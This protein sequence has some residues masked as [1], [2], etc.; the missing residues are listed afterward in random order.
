MNAINY[1]GVISIIMKNKLWLG[2][3]PRGEINFITK[4]KPSKENPVVE[5]KDSTISLVSACWFTNMEHGRRHEPL[6][7]MT[8]ADNLKYNK[9]VIKEPKTYLKYDNYDMIEVPFTNAIP[10]DYNGVMGVPISFLEKYNPEQFEILDIT[11]RNDDPYKIKTYSKKE[12]S[13]AND[14]NA[15]GVIILNNIPKSMYARILI[16][17]KTK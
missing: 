8:M 2:A 4:I 12:Y 14:L 7:L 15:G 9:K 16:R 17:H 11:Q 5:S 1:K 6:Q 10:S 13:N 3:S